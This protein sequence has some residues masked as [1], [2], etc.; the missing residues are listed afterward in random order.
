[1]TILTNLFV[2]NIVWHIVCMCKS[3]I[4]LVFKKVH[5]PHERAPKGTVDYMF[6]KTTEQHSKTIYAHFRALWDLDVLCLDVLDV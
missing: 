2:L 5:C 1:M 6:S 4:H 3:V